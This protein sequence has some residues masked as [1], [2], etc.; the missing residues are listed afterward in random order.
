M[1]SLDWKER[2]RKDTKDFFE[3]KIPENDYDFDIIYNAYPERIENK[4]PREVVTFVAKKLASKLAKE[5][6]KYFDF[7]D[8][9]WNEKGEDGKHAFAYIM[10]KV[11]KKNP[12]VFIPYVEK[13]IKNVDNKHECN[14]ILDKAIFPILKKDPK[15]HLKKMINWLKTD[16]KFIIQGV[17]RLLIKIIKKKEDMVD[18]IT[19]SLE[20]L[21]LHADEEFIRSIVKYIK[22]IYK[23]NPDYY[24]KIYKR[25][26]HSR[27]PIFAE[28]L[29]NSIVVYDQ[30]I[31]KMTDSWASS[32]NV[33]LKK[34][35]KTG[36]RTIKRK[37][38][39]G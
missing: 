20:N 9:I 26:E 36:K 1:I 18:P 16:N 35:G 13:I 21:W 17:I 34:A 31:E 2:L 3:R 38:K 8:Y 15:K 29:A 39:N 32:G 23:V 19:K 24:L 6:E 37:K 4:V 11:A 25:Y 5:P 14:M 10:A 30:T 22:A 12:D 33:K 27:E 28:I 7:Y